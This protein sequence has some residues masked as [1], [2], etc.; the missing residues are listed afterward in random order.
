MKLLNNKALTKK[1]FV[2]GIDGLDPR[3]TKRLLNEGKM[4]NVKKLMEKGAC[5][6]DLMMLGANPTM[7]PPLWATLATGTYPM[8][9]GI[10]DYNMAMPDARDISYGA[11]S[12]RF[13]KAEPIWNVTAQS[14]K[15]TLVLHWPGGSFP[16][17]IDSENLISIDGS[18]PGSCC[19]WA[20]GIGADTLFV[21]SVKAAK[22]SFAQS[23][24][25]ISDIEGDEELQNGNALALNFGVTEEAKNRKKHYKQVYEEMLSIEGYKPHGSM[26]HDGLLFDEDH[27]LNWTLAD[28]AV[29]C[30]ISPISNA[31]NWDIEIPEDAKEFLL[32]S[33]NAR[34]KKYGLILKNT[35]GIYDKVAIYNSKSDSNPVVVLE[36]DIFTGF[37]DV[38]KKKESNEKVHCNMRVLKIAE[39]GSYVR[40]WRS[41]LMSCENDAVWY[42]KSVFNEIMEQVGPLHAS[43]SVSGNDKD[44]IMK[45]CHPQWEQAA[46]WQS[47][48]IHY[49]I[50]KYGVEVI[51]SHFHNIDMQ[52]HNYLKYMKNRD[53]S[54]YDESEVLKFAEATYKLTDDYVGSF[55]HLIDEGWTIFLLSDHGLLCAEE[56]PHALGE[57]SGVNV[58]PLRGFGYTVLK[59]DENGNEIPEIDWTKTTAIQVG[60]NSI[61]LN[62]KGRDPYG[63][64][65]PEDKYEVEEKIITDLYGYKDA[66]T[67]HRIVTMALRNKDAVLL[68]LGGPLGADII[69][70]RHET[71]LND[72]GPGLSTSH[73]YNDTSLSPLFIAAGP[74]IKQNFKT[75]RWIREVD[76]APT[77]S[78]LL[79]VNIP[80]DCEGAPVYQILEE[81]F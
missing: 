59:V 27:G 21:A 54:R 13:L 47:D 48:S 32:L 30:S 39:D 76:V 29:D 23:A 2:L 12:S 6:E 43:S 45:C 14:G 8:T 67:G 62:V 36:N 50:Q 17:T 55:L 15:K 69:I 3:F 52:N 10:I 19:A 58:D 53:T 35:A 9:H 31:E 28:S 22:P 33:N 74:G 24:V 38:Y 1:L 63:I 73:G 42:P 66:K 57:N 4:P 80:K 5:R 41:P 44:L 7:T 72:H 26:L 75:S 25:K 16:P 77:I 71:Y 34:N 20:N 81:V 68:G 11:F 49:F 18:S 65:A 78:V 40:I 70:F 61:Y 56:V 37:Y 79:G 51:F 46:K 60:S 64:I